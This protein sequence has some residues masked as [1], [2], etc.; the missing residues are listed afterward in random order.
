MECFLFCNK[1]FDHRTSLFGNAEN[2]G[3]ML[4]KG[5]SSTKN[6]KTLNMDNTKL[7]KRTWRFGS[8]LGEP[9]EVYRLEA[10]NH[11]TLLQTKRFSE[12]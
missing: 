2:Y 3:R 12:L 8:L 5:A 1:Q 6:A 7:T 10:G 11:V 4:L 9:F